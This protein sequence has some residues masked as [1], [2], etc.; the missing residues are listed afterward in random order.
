MSSSAILDL[1]TAPF[2]GVDDLGVYLRSKE[3]AKR[4]IYHGWIQYSVRTGGTSGPY[5]FAREQV[6]ALV[7]RIRAGEVPPAMPRKGREE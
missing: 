7:A 3:L 6:D 2:L 1:N 4:S 5:L